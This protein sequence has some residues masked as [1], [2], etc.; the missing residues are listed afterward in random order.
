MSDYPIELY[1]EQYLL[2]KICSFPDKLISFLINSSTLIAITGFSLPFFS[3]LLYDINVDFRLLLASYLVTFA[4]YSLN[5]LTDMK[6]DKINL[7]NRAEFTIKNRYYIILSVIISSFAAAYLASS[8]T[9]FAILIIFFPFC[10]GF[11]YSIKVANFRLKDI[12][13][14][15]SLSVALAWAVIGAFIPIVVDSR[16]IKMI[17]FVFVFFFIKLFINTVIF[18]VR[19]INGD[20]LSGVRTIPVFLGRKKTK[21][22]LLIMNSILI[23]WLIFSYFLGFFHRYFIV[24]IFATVYGYWYILYFCRET[25]N[26]RMSRDLLVDGEFIGIAILASLHSYSSIFL[27]NLP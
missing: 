12:I 18:D 17:S 15:K 19:D 5:K 6:E 13:F 10:I 2:K 20:S 9:I 26:I 3:F 21:I 4:V 22:L 14:M 25:I 1:K 24:L 11:I 7:Q 16:G 23:F 8:Y 27:L